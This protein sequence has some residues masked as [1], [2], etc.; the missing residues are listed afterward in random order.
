L[1]QGV[2]SYS[3]RTSARIRRASDSYI[4]FDDAQSLRRG[5]RFPNYV[6]LAMIILTV[7]GLAYSVYTRAREQ[8][9]EARNSYNETSAQ[10]E[11]AR[12]VNTQIKN[13]TD[14]IRQN[15]EAAAQAAQSQ[16]RM[17]R[18]NEVVVSLK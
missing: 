14:R 5:P 2:N 10:V 4:G 7:A 17:I 15:P 11:N 12:S 1:R 13:Q 3:A 16:S 6:W 18:R 9:R 8:E